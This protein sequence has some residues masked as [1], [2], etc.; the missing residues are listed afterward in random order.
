MSNI[1]SRINLQIKA[2]EANPSPPIGPVLGSKGINIIQF[3]KSFN[4]MTSNIQN[5]EK[6]TLVTAS[7]NIYKDKT[8]FLTIK[9]PPVTFLLK[10]AAN[11]EKGSNSPNLNKVGYVTIDQLKNIVSIKK[12]DLLSTS[13]EAS[14][15]I[16]KGSALSMGLIIKDI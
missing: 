10:K 13:L 14:L 5:I 11:I 6:G 16:I 1:I 7:I 15:N 4:S 8:F 12:N 2:G 3:C 9:T